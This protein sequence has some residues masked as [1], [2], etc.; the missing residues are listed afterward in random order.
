MGHTRPLTSDQA[1]Q[2]RMEA[3]VQSPLIALTQLLT[4]LVRMKQG[5]ATQQ[6]SDT[7]VVGHTSVYTRL[8]QRLKPTASCH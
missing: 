3:Q 5:V 1:Y 4:L 6:A 2:R 8:F 7:R